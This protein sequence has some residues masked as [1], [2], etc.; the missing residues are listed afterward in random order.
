M[1]VR[2][3]G[4]LTAEVTCNHCTSVVT[5]PNATVVPFTVDRA[6]VCAAGIAPPGW[7]VNVS[8]EGDADRFGPLTVNYAVPVTRAPYDVVQPFSFGAGSF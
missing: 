8:I 1:T 7:N 4:A 6:M 3:A 5:D 2:V